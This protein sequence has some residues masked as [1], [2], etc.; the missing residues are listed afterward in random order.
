V[1]ARE[2]LAALVVLVGG[3]LWLFV[4]D[5][6]HAAGSLLDDSTVARWKLPPGRGLVAWV[7]VENRGP[8]TV[9]LTGASIGSEL[10]EGTRLLGVRARIGEVAT[11][12]DAFPG[13]PGP[14]LRLEGFRIPPRRGATVGFGLSFARPGP[15]RLEDA[16][17]RY[18]EGGE[19]H[20]LRARHTARVCVAVRRRGC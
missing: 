8:H 19:D 16:T 9:T 6:R 4:P 15:V 5:K 11:V 20:E 18:R 14:F 7:L 17:V 13:P 3:T 10:P 1:R 12:D 2:L